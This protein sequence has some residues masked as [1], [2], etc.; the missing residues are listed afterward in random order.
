MND[1]ELERLADLIAERVFDKLISKQQEWDEQFN[2]QMTEVEW[3]QME[4]RKDDFL[5]SNKK[6]IEELK[7]LLA[8]AINEEDYIAASKI[9]SKI[10]DLKNKK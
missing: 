2:E 8:K 5:K 7:E 4:Y 9:N 10:V 6:K 1:K 3:N